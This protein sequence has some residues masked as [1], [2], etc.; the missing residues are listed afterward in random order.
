MEYGDYTFGTMKSQKNNKHDN[1]YIHVNY[2]VPFGYNY[3]RPV[4]VY[5]TITDLLVYTMNTGGPSKVVVCGSWLE[6]MSK[7]PITGNTNKE[8]VTRLMG[9]RCTCI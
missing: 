7:Y 1:S 9:N 6:V 3:T 2:N 5:V 8:I 4:T